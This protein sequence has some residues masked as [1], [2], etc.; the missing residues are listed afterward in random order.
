MRRTILLRF[1]LVVAMLFSATMSW[2]QVSF[3]ADAPS[4]VALGEPFR[5]EFSVDHRPDD[6]TFKAPQFDDFEVLA[7]P[8][9]STGTSVQ[10]INGRQTSSYSCTYTFVLLPK[11]AGLFEIGQASVAVDGKRYTTSKLPIEVLDEGEKAKAASA[12]KSAS[13]EQSIGKEDILL[14]WEISDNDIYKGES[15]K[16]SLMLYSRVE[17]AEITALNVA[18]FN[19]FWTQELRVD[20]AMSRKE[21]KGRIYDTYKIQEYLLSPQ[22]SG[23]QN[24]D[25]TTMDVLVPVTVQNSRNIDPFFGGRQ[26]YLVTRTLTSEPVK[27]TVKEF[28]AG[29]PA[30]FN[31]AVGRFKIENTTPPKQMSVNSAEDISITIS[32]KGNFKFI[33]A[34]TLVMP[35][36]FEVYDAKISENVK[37][38][39]SGMEGSLT[40]TYPFVARAAGDFE[41]API[42]FSYLDPEDGKYKTL[43]TEPFVLNITGDGG[44]YIPKMAEAA[45]S[46]EGF[47]Y[48][49]VKQLGRDIRYIHTGS[50][51]GKPSAAFIFTPI[52]WL[53]VVIIIS[54]FVVAFIILRQRIRANR[55]IVAR[56]MKH[57]DKVAVQRLRI[58]YRWLNEGNKHSFYEE[59]LRAMWGYIGDKFNIP[60][61]NLTKETIREELYR[62]GASTEDAEQ[63][64]QIISRADEAQYAPTT[65]GDM[66]EVYVDAVDMIT[67]IESVVKH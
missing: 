19:D 15:V 55:N 51:P 11:G 10:F 1:C 14:I 42:H 48:G 41:I 28:P 59:L 62:R 38:S 58:A 44:S 25:A 36:S 61:S 39:S 63:F 64:C 33:T 27:I 50:L 37:S 54:L 2:A 67:K 22:R 8:S 47:N 40:Y 45:H 53:V 18:P 13:P 16:A 4:L 43:A 26:T 6:G 66:N 17:V 30:S 5:V 20:N 56:R 32:G 23:V 12:K 7:G 34:P 65:D 9:V 46:D 24:F 3:S 57:A 49:S 29:A 35:N 31:G 21:Y 52:Y 60:V